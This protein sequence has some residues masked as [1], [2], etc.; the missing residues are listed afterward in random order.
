MS[1]GQ[2]LNGTYFCGR[3]MD[4]KQRYTAAGFESP[5][6]HTG[7]DSTS[8]CMLSEHSTAATNSPVAHCSRHF[9]NL[10]HLLSEMDF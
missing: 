4:V 6:A 2:P 7:I 10:S 3:P 8:S 1:A 5:V 9:D